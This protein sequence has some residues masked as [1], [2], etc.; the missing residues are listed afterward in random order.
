MTLKEID[1]E[2]YKNTLRIRSI[3]AWTKRVM[4]FSKEFET[5]IEESI[6]T[7]EAQ[8]ALAVE[9]VRE[10]QRLLDSGSC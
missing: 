1:Q 9:R 4:P 10:M 8:E 7:Q 5:L 3:E 6:K 2:M